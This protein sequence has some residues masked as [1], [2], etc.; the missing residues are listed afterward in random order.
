MIISKCSILHFQVDWVYLRTLG[1]SSCLITLATTLRL[2]AKRWLYLTE[3][4]KELDKTLDQL[5]RCAAKRI[6]E[7]F[8]VDPQTA[9]TLLA[10][11]G[12]NPERPHS[13]GAL[14]SLCGV[15]PLEVSSGKTVRHR[16]KRGGNRHANN[17]LWTSLWFACGVIH[18]LGHMLHGEH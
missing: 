2:L 1:E 8:G 14:A 9:A 12:D 3:E 13:E 7:Q 18:G 5:T 6:L 17:P 4:L 16:L 11:A 10:V 15:S